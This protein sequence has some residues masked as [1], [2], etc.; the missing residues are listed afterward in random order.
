MGVLRRTKKFARDRTVLTVYKGF[1]NGSLLRGGHGEAEFNC[2]CHHDEPIDDGGVLATL[3]GRQIF[4]S[5]NGGPPY[6][7][8][9]TNHSAP[10][11]VVRV[12]R[13]N[14]A[15]SLKKRQNVKSW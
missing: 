9:Q 13:G 4:D 5:S 12:P 11:G 7:I 1:A 14:L 3:V 10:P 8:A 15:T 2:D 6:L